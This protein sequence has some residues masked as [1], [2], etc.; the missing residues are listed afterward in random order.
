[1]AT[2]FRW[3]SL[4]VSCG[5]L[6][7]VALFVTLLFA[8]WLG[9]RIRV[10]RIRCP[11][12]GRTVGWRA[13][14]SAFSRMAKSRRDYI[15]AQNDPPESF[16]DYEFADILDVSCPYC[17]HWFEHDISPTPNSGS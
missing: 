14:S 6:L 5:L 17:S 1:M 7:F 12:C 4:I 9:S 11:Q 13:G 15:A 8:S 10:S 2:F 3:L 16:V